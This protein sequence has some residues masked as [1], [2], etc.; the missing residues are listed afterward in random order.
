MGIAAQ[1]RARRISC[2]VGLPQHL[3]AL[4]EEIEPGYLQSMLL[5]SDYAA[6]ALRRRIEAA[7]GCTTFLHYGTTESGLGGAV[8]RPEHQGCHIRESELLMEIVDPATGKVLPDGETGEVVIT[9]L[10]REAMPLLRYRSGDMAGLE[11]SVCP[12]GG[13]T[14]RLVDIRGRYSGC[15]LPGGS[16]LF[17]YELDDCLF[18]IPG[19]LDYRI[20][21]EHKEVDLLHVDF[22]A[23]ADEKP[24]ADEIRRR[25]LQVPAILESLAGRKFAIGTIRRVADFTASHTVKRTI[26]DK[27]KP[28]VK[29]AAYS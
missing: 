11:R 24:D 25:L 19:L 29:N 23:V 3:L 13:V 22:V 21:L 5:C 2:V 17:S 14:A 28:G 12:C 15:A 26:L 8:A 18:G 7:C 10:G 6:P 27:R 4:A 1:I 16:R 20:V 9:T